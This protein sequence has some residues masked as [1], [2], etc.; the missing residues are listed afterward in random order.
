MPKNSRYKSIIK[1]IAIIGMVIFIAVSIL[2]I[3]LPYSKTTIIV[4]ILIDI[5]ILISIEA[6]IMKILNSEIKNEK[7]QNKKEKLKKTSEDLKSL[8]I[9]INIPIIFFVFSIL[10]KLLDSIITA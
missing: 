4:T 10:S 7:D 2:P 5:F 1:R 3:I 6:I 9:I 8:I